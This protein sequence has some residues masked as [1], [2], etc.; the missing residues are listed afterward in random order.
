MMMMAQG[1]LV[2]LS[3]ALF[4]FVFLSLQWSLGLW[5]RIIGLQFKIELISFFK[6]CFSLFRFQTK[7]HDGQM[8]DVSSPRVVEV[9]I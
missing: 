8:V 4:F 7:P 9:K 6:G 5:L 3:L 1:D 2:F